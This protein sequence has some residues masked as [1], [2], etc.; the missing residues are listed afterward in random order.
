MDGLYR[1][2]NAL[3]RG[4]ATTVYE[5]HD[6]RLDRAVAIKEVDEPYASNEA[7]VGAFLN[8]ASRMSAVVHSNVLTIHA[9]DSS[10]EPPW[11][12]L[13]LADG[14]TLRHLMARGPG[15]P[16]QAAQILRQVLPG[17]A[18]I[19]RWGLVHRNVKPENVFLC[20]N[21]FKIGDFGVT[22]LADG[23]TL[24]FSTPKYIPPEGFQSPGRLAPASDLYAL[25]LVIYEFLLG[26][27]RFRQ[28]VEELLR[29]DS[30][31]EQGNRGEDTQPWFR[32]H[33]GTSELPPLHTIDSNVP[34]TLSR[35]VQKMMHKDLA[36]RYASCDEALAD[37]HGGGNKAGG[38]Q[39]E[40][41]PPTQTLRR[42][43][44]T[45][46]KSR[47][48]L[49]IT[50]AAVLL[51]VLTAFGTWMVS[52]RRA[53]PA[54]KP[55]VAKP[56]TPSPVPEASPPPKPP[57][58]EPITPAR[59]PDAEALANALLALRSP[60]GG[61]ELDFEPPPTTYRPR[62]PLDTPLRFRLVSNRAGFVALFS[63][64]SDGSIV[65]LYPNQS[66]TALTVDA[67]QLSLPLEE[68]LR[69]GF[70]IVTSPPFGRDF[71]FALTSTAPLRPPP[72]GVAP[73]TWLTRYAFLPG[74]VESP[75][76]NFARWVREVR[77][78]RPEE[79][80]LVAREMDITPD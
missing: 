28:V 41:E 72:A 32:L 10:H 80:R 17:L 3:G 49:W 50:I 43:S 6:Q 19:H 22:A 12:I 23:R 14:G 1:K 46:P 26:E 71:I 67:V 42:I 47:L 62:M 20:K 18:E 37:L 55:L 60:D 53:K 40:G 56:P 54:P 68:D 57:E 21:M 48:G 75:A 61:L 33:L 58:P 45:E 27:A 5:G 44:E 36:R 35:V 30:A 9:V 16:A 2:G 79:T 64:S 29:E 7:F 65:L 38:G 24:P 4:S 66:R 63:V 52:G 74:G 77:R 34:E 76:L 13:E 39:P 69:A 31:P 78:G 51:I 11:L 59:I 70:R 8:E 73:D 15:Q 25:G